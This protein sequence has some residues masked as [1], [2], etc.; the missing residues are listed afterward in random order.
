MTDH[1]IYSKS[2][3]LSALIGQKLLPSEG[4]FKTL[5]LMH[6]ENNNEPLNIFAEI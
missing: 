2:L 3:F 1:T 5:K 6:R 4:R